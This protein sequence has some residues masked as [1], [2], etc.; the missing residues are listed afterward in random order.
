MSDATVSRSDLMTLLNQ[1]WEYLMRQCALYRDAGQPIPV[2]LQAAE[3]RAFGAV[4]AEANFR[5]NLD[6]AL[7]LEPNV[8][9][10]WD[11]HRLIWGDVTVTDT[12]REAEA[13]SKAAPPKPTPDPVTDP[14]AYAPNMDPKLL[15]SPWA[16]LVAEG[17]NEI[18]ET[19]GAEIPMT[20]GR[21][22]YYTRSELIAERPGFKGE[23]PNDTLLIVFHDGGILSRYGG[24]PGIWERI[25]KWLTPG[26]YIIDPVNA[27]TT[28]IRH[29]E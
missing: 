11:A 4:L 6:P 14:N 5:S 24:V 20:G 29:P 9:A 21:R 18:L 8:Q 22:I 15:G 10:G 12:Q 27:A 26:R 13:L 17:I 19:H 1:R 28:L 7:P 2:V 16:R 23:F 3:E 25:E